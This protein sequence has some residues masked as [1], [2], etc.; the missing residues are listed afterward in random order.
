MTPPGQHVSARVLW[1]SGARATLPARPGCVEAPLCADGA[2]RFV[3]RA[4]SIDQVQASAPVRHLLWWA[5]RRQGV[6]AGGVVHVLLPLSLLP[7]RFPLGRARRPRYL[8]Q[9][10]LL[11]ARR[12]ETRGKKW[13]PLAWSPPSRSWTTRTQTAADPRRS[14]SVRTA[15]PAQISTTFAPDR[16]MDTHVR[17]PP[18]HPLSS[19]PGVP[20]PASAATRAG[21]HASARRGRPVAPPAAP[22]PP[23][24]PRV[25]AP[26][27]RS[28]HTHRHTHTHTHDRESRVLVK[29]EAIPATDHSRRRPARHG[30]GG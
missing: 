26:P 11:A 7:P 19:G 15:P 4:N 3:C 13:R 16:H 27:P 24:A 17:V 23:P 1:P 18:C 10:G 14:K 9:R 5:P 20:R 28:G 22:L 21:P 6:A 30:L 12:R 29:G 25:P 2:A 8:G